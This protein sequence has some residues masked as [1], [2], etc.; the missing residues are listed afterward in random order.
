MLAAVCPS[1]CLLRDF[2]LEQ[3]NAVGLAYCHE[4]LL[5]AGNPP[6]MLWHL[7]LHHTYMISAGLN[8]TH[9]CAILGCTTVAEQG[10]AGNVRARQ[11][12]CVSVDA[13][14]SVSGM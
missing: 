13:L 9:F 14:A 3:L 8:N 7:H 6:A 2:V 11:L 4:S 5:P 1:W 10:S 12:R